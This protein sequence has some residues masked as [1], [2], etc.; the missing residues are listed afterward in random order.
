MEIVV[1]A[2]R[3]DK[4]SRD[5]SF[6]DEYFRFETQRGGP[7]SVTFCMDACLAPESPA[8]INI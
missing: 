1:I 3:T 6:D 7:A 8:R 2:E 4:P 5:R